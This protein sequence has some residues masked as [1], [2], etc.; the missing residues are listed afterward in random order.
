MAKPIPFVGPP[1]Q[2]DVSNFDQRFVNVLFEVEKNANPAQYPINCVK[3]PGLSSSTQPFGGAATGRGIYYWAATGKIYSVFGTSTYANASTLV[4]TMAT[5]SGRV[6]F[7][8]SNV[9]S[10]NQLL[11]IS[12]GLD[13]YV[14]TSTDVVTQVD[15]SDDAQYPTPNT[16]PIVYLDG[17][18]FQGQSNGK[19]WNSELNASSSWLAADYVPVD[20]HGGA[21]EAHLLQKDQI[22]AFTKNR[23]EFFFNNGNP[24]NSPLLRIDQNTLGFGIASK[25]SLAW[26][27][28]TACFVSENSANGD[29]GRSVY[30]MQSLQNVKEISDPP[31]NRI[32]AAEGQSIS[33][34]SAWMERLSGHLVYCLNLASADRSF[35]YDI[36]AGMW[37]EAESATSTRLN[38]VSATSKDGTVFAQHATDGR[39]YTFQPTVYQDNGTNFEVVLQ[40]SRS[41]FGSHLKKYETEL[42]LVGDT[43]TGTVSVAVSDNDNSSFTT[44]GTIDMGSQFKT[45]TRLG[46]FY[47]RV[48]RF[49]FAA[50]APFRVQ[51]FMPEIRVGTG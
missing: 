37:S 8:E 38:L 9:L 35:V 1:G 22:A 42:G 11:Y 34:C 23:V 33:S 36:E 10:G 16:G 4:S 48:H 46:A 45:I 6:W 30:M 2:R 7:A 39:I 19:L 31:L 28:E 21:L 41:N 14:I 51:A 17:Y 18:L 43:S 13:N 50:N 49:T 32:L 24:T 12:D 26:A 40:T 20:T 44:V 5:S 3:R 47:S 29:G 27:G 15:E 25:A